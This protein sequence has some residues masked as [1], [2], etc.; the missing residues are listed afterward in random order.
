[1]YNSEYISCPKIGFEHTS[2]ITTKEY[3]KANG[4]PQW[5]VLYPT[6]LYSLEELVDDLDKAHDKFVKEASDAFE[7][8]YDDMLDDKE[9][10]EPACVNCCRCCARVPPSPPAAAHRSSRHPRPCRRASA[11]STA[12]RPRG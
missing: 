11:C 9:N 2:E 6:T 3:N 8:A 10:E 5:D 12:R 7:Q 1:M 4:S